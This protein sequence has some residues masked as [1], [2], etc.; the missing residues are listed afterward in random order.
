MFFIFAPIPGEMIQFDHRI[1]QMGWFNHQ[2]DLSFM[3][4][5]GPRLSS[6]MSERFFFSN[7]HCRTLIQIVHTK[8]ITN[9]TQMLHV[10]NIYLHLA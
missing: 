1:F 8:S 10:G 5:P 2:L 6:M 7:Y 3:G 4:P 9:I